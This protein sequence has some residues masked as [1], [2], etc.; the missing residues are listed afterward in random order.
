MM[1]WVMAAVLAAGP[2]TAQDW[3]MR[4]GDTLL[5]PE[6]LTARLAG[7]VLEFHDGAQSIYFEDGKYNFIYGGGGTWYGYW[8][9]TAP[10][11]VCVEYLN[12][13]R[14]C[15]RVVIN[16]DRFEVLTREG[17]RFPVR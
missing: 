14:R 9:V 6:A 10:G 17:E 11:T 13:T 5:E 4:D 12:D 2:V 16:D 3:K 7:Q 8:E 15:D 1:R